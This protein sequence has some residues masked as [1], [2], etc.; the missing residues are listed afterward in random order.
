M[1]YVVRQLLQGGYGDA[2]G[3]DLMAAS[4][5]LRDPCDV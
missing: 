3:R 2:T 5:R 1:N 4:A